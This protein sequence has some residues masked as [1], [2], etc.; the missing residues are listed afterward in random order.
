M[1]ADSRWF[2]DSNNPTGDDTFTLRRAR[3][4]IEGT[5]FNLFDFRFMPRHPRDREDEKVV[6]GRLQLYF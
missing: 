2:F 6:L 1:H 3:P 5:V 4:F